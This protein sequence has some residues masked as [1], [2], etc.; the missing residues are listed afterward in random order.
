MSSEGAKRDFSREILFCTLIN[1]NSF[2]KNLENALYQLGIIN[3]EIFLAEDVKRRC[4][5]DVKLH[6]KNKFSN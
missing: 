5:A 3:G 1:N 4:K 6:I 2:R